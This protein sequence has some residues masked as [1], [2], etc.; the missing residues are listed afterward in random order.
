MSESPNVF[1]K[2]NSF[3]EIRQNAR[4]Y[5]NV[6]ERVRRLRDVLDEQSYSDHHLGIIRRACDEVIDGSSPGESRFQLHDHV[7]EEINRL[8]DEHLSRYLF[9]RY[10]YDIFPPTQQLD[11][12]PPCLQIEPASTCNY[13]CVF[14]YQTDKELTNPENGHMGLMSMDLFKHVVDQAEGTCEA[15][16]LASRGEPLIHRHIED[17]LSYAS[18][19]FLALKINTN[20]WFLDEHKCHSIL[21]AG[22]N[23]LVFSA[24]AASEPLYSQ[25][26][27]RGKLDRVVSNIRQFQ[28]IRARHYS[29]S[30]TI[31]R[32]S[33][34]RV[35]DEQNLDDMD[36]FWGDLVDQVA[37]V[38]YNPWENT[39][40]RPVNDISDPC[41]DLW[42]RMFVWWDGTVN[43]CDVDYLSTL[44]VGD[45]NHEGLSKIWGGDKYDALRE[46]HLSRRRNSISPCMRCTLV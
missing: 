3:L 39:Y 28:D 11:D 6:Y 13:R 10:R 46:A 18:G 45:A 15:V 14:C 23:T 5:K 12:F 24:D 19:K 31:T 33:G 4:D 16:T 44:A 21:Q 22:V 43:P 30:G 41:S 29:D 34:V 7:T 36:L 40:Q 37:F 25:L 17:M 2:A 38:K 9:Y 8:S 32:V 20:A 42:R 1:K 27:V 35:G 26:R